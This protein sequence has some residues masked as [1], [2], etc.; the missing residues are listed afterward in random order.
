MRIHKLTGI[1]KSRANLIKP[2][3]D[4]LTFCRTIHSMVYSAMKLFMEVNP[5][6]FD[7]CSDQHRH[8]E[9]QS[10]KRRQTRDARWAQIEELAKQRQDAKAGRM[11]NGSITQQ[12]TTNRSPPRGDRSDSFGQDAYRKFDQL[13]ISE[14]GPTSKAAVR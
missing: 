13:R 9:D 8:E 3:D 14:E 2:F 10:Q 7:E 6:L 12:Q 5:T 11:S 4:A 1:G